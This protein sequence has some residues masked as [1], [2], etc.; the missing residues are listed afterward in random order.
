MSRHQ[1]NPEFNLSLQHPDYPELPLNVTIRVPVIAAWDD[2]NREW[3]ATSPHVY[4]M[5][6]TG[7]DEDETA[8]A[9]AEYLQGQVQ[10]SLKALMNRETLTDI[11][12]ISTN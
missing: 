1:F 8:Q 5:R 4:G 6:V 7:R 9:V 10:S 11:G 3:V 2:E 12:S